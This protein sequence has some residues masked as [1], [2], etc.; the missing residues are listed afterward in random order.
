MTTERDE[1]HRAI[2]I[3][4]DRQWTTL[5]TLSDQCFTLLLDAVG[6]VYTAL[7]VDVCSRRIPAD[8]NYCTQHVATSVGTH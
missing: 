1:A 3:F 2:S 6:F 4:V 8:R 7:L 5:P